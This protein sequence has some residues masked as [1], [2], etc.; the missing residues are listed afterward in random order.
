MAQ[1]VCYTVGGKHTSADGRQGLGE[2]QHSDVH[3]IGQSEMRCCTAPAGTEHTE[4]VRIVHHHTRA[5][6][7]RQLAYLRQFADI[8]T[9]GEDTIGDNQF[10]GILRDRFELAL[11]ILHIRMT[12]AKHFRITQTASVI[13]R[14]VVLTVIEDVIIFTRDSG[15]DCEVGLETRGDRHTLF[16]SGEFGNLL[17]QLQ[18]QVQ[19]A[20]QETATAD[21]CSVFV[22]C[23]VTRFDNRLVL[24]KTEVVIAAKHDDAMVLHLH[25]RRLAT[26]Q[27][28]EIGVDTQFTNLLEGLEMVTFFE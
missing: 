8:A 17:F 28:V 5:V 1:P 18:M 16:V 2:G 12:I 26:L 22:Q 10:A 4:T 7:L 15:D 19:R 11:Q 24:R 25:H 23:F 27:L 3:L 14:S 13:D 20:V 9:H 6:F 21:T